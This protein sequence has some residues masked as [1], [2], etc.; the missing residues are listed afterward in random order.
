M[1]ADVASGILEAAASCDA[2]I[3]IVRSRGHGASP[4]SGAPT[5]SYSTFRTNPCLSDL[6]DLRSFGTEELMEGQ[7]DKARP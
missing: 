6:G 2:G 1:L 3:V 7:Q 5:T 4:C